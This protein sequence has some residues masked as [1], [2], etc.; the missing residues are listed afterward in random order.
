MKAKNKKLISF[1]LVFLTINMGLIA[2]SI[3]ANEKSNEK[4]MVI[5][6]PFGPTSDVPDPRARQNGWMS[7]RAGVSETLLG[8]DDQMNLVGRLAAEHHNITPTQWKVVL[9]PG[10]KFHDGSHVDAYAVKASFEKITLKDH[11][12]YNIRLSK[13][14][15][16]KSIEVPSA[17]TLIFTTQKPNAA[18]PWA[19]TEP[20]AAVMKEGN[21][22]FP[23]IGTGPF[24]FV[25]ASAN[26]NYQVQA[27]ADYRDGQPKAASIRFDAI[28]DST[29]AMLALKSGD[30]DLVTN[31]P[32][33]DF[34]ALKKNGKGQLFSNSTTRLFF[35]QLRVADGKLADPRIRQALSLA[36]DRDMI[37]DAVLSGVGGKKANSIFPEV[38]KSWHNPKMNLAYDPEK[39]RALLKEAGATDLVIH[40][41]SYEGR[42][43]LKPTLE[44]TQALLS[45]IG[46]KAVIGMGEF[47]AN[48]D[49]LKSG[50]IHMHLQAWGTA[51]IG[52][53]SYF[54]ETLLKSDASYNVGGYANSE[55]D[56]LL[57][58]G[59]VE[60]DLQ[61]R[62]LIFDQVQALINR[63][64]PLIP[65]FHK[66]QT[67][68]GSGKVVG[69][70]IH[71]AETYLTNIW[72]GKQQ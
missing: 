24:V 31:F 20:S 37:V 41:R 5:A 40:L 35:Y 65:L 21:E 29:T 14:L 53:P 30:V 49:A 17:D 10:V 12:A 2:A 11:P 38:M 50:E 66:N 44:V 43:A 60:F 46:V 15:D 34:A 54:P 26:K 4:S 59:R 3:N 16:L 23:L 67:S 63:D 62:K 6:L 1:F 8:L 58:E 42:A 32:E 28:S 68:V 51:P 13:L 55:L 27:F 25:S 52:D 45:Q 64:L 56:R 9:K 61:K 18:F 69:Y 19:L 33:N 36:L 70:K 72:L 22:K 57:E 39:A 48:N 7:N 47:G 71:P